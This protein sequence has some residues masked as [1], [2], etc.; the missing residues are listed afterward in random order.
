MINS[1]FTYEFMQN[2]IIGGILAS[3][4][5]GIIGTIIIEKK[6]IML[7]GGIAHTSFGGIGFGYFL[8]IEPII[9][10]Y[11][12]S[13][14]SAIGLTLVHK[15]NDAKSDDAAIGILWAVGM[16]LGILFISIA[17]GYPPDMTSYLFGD[18]LT[19]TKFNISLMLLTTIVVSALILPF[20]KYWESYLFDHE[21]LRIHGINTSY[22]DFGLFLLVSFSIV[23]LIKLVGIILVI[24]LMTIP[25]SVAKLF[26][27]NLRNI[28][29]LSIL[30]GIL[31]T[32]IG[33]FISYTFN[34]PSG[35]SIIIFSASCYFILRIFKK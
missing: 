12:I 34:I 18:I 22:F 3:I 16:S 26:T 8:G 17:P 9:G 19:I 4:L 10:A 28:M 29:I 13:T 23:S 35:S 5:C 1:I 15:K 27:R 21:F 7:S 25:P 2:A 24:A 6:L 30:L 31:F 20:F 14:L 11:I 32:F 33:L